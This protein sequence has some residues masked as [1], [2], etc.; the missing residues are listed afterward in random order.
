[1][2]DCGFTALS[3]LFV[4]FISDP[5]GLYISMLARRTFQCQR[6]KMNL[7]EHFYRLH[8]LV[9]EEPLSRAYEQSRTIYVGIFV[10]EKITRRKIIS[11]ERWKNIKT[12]HL[13]NPSEELFHIAMNLCVPH[14]QVPPTSAHQYLESLKKHVTAHKDISTAV[15]YLGYIIY[16]N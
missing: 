9:T 4:R 14:Y 15:S 8:F 7:F 5:T 10:N 12:F 1:M 16:R 3:Q 11:K 2:L 13:I 6:L